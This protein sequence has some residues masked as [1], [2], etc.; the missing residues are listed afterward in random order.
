MDFRFERPATVDQAIALL[1]G[2]P[3]SARIL[4]GGTD[5]LVALRAGASRTALVV[6][7]KSIPGIDEIRWSPDGDLVIGAAV[8]VQR[9]H[10]DR[11][12][13]R[14]YPALADGAGNIGSLQIRYRATVGGNL[15][16]ASPCMDTAPPLLVLGARVRT[17]GP[18]GEREIA[19]DS[20]FI[21]V[22]ETVLFRDEF[23][24]SITVPRRARDG[25]PRR[26]SEFGGTISPW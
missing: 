23:L 3:G 21:G 12:I 9:I 14:I 2:E 5:L 4:A 25:A 7:I 15:A 1:A 10:D 26:S 17:A 6:D 19:L 24:L 22:K 13:A 20:F 8:P 11:E 16:N 18:R